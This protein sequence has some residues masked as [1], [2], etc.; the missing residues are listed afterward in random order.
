MENKIL[1]P[2]CK[3][4]NIVEIYE[5]S[6]EEISNQVDANK[7]EI[8]KEIEKIWKNNRCTFVKCKKCSFS[9]A[10]PFNGGSEQFYRKLYSTNYP[11]N[12]WEYNL[13]LKKISDK[14]VCLEIGSGRGVFINQLKKKGNIKGI[15]SVEISNSKADYKSIK[16]I[17]NEKKF[18]VI[19]MFQVLEHLDNFK[20]VFNK[21]NKISFAN[22]KMFI[23][24]PH[25]EGVEFFRTNIGFGDNP[26]IHVSRWNKNTIEMATGW[27]I[28]EYKV[29]ERGRFNLWKDIFFGIRTKR[30]SGTRNPL[31]LLN[32]LLETLNKIP[33][34]KIKI[35]Q[36]F[37]LEKNGK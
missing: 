35:T 29:Q 33:P 26:P 14:D 16:D 25:E 30:Y 10:H 27:K 28:K 8:K 21:I 2:L 13:T 18:S 12:R 36:W 4:C 3:S 32:I 23:S 11:K 20:E 15:Y 31:Y 24:V 9:F 5:V 19:C 6:S 22:S 1:C 7:K 17:S 34:K 37:Y